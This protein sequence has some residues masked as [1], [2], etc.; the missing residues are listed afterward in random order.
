[1]MPVGDVQRIEVGKCADQRV[2]IGTGHVAR[3][4]CTTPSARREVV[5]RLR[6]RH[7][8][9]DVVDCLARAIGQEHEARL[10][11]QLGDV[12]RA[13]VFLVLARL[14]VLLDET[15]LVFVD[16]KAPAEPGLLV[17]AHPQPVD[18]ERRL[19]VSSQAAPSA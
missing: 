10:R 14:L 3:R 1:M 12:A 7:A 16:R 17:R 18:V 15:A 11:A 9:R 4:V 13:V 5:E 6:P 2:T 8:R 19:L